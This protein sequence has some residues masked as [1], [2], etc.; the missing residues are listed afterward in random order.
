LPSTPRLIVGTG[1]SEISVINNLALFHEKSVIFDNDTLIVDDLDMNADPTYLFS[2]ATGIG[3]KDAIPLKRTEIVEDGLQLASE[4]IIHGSINGGKTKAQGT[5][6]NPALTSINIKK[7]KTIR[8]SNNDSVS[9]YSASALDQVQRK[10][11][12]GIKITSYIFDTE[13][14]IKP[15]RTARLIDLTHKINSVFY[16]SSVRYQKSINEGSIIIINMIPADVSFNVMWSSNNTSVVQPETKS[17]E[18]LL[19]TRK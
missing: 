3:I 10:F 17:L 5:A 8:S 19:A 7:R 6:T 16:I 13:Y 2:Y 4:I 14:A 12:E 18:E 9:K 11:R 1:E 15:N